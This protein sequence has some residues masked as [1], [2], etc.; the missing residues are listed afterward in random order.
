MKV[1]LEG[2]NLRLGE[3]L[4][5]NLIF[6]I[7]LPRSGSTLL[8]HIIASHSTVAATAE[9]WILFP[10]AYALRPGALSANYNADIGRIALSEFLA[11]LDDGEE[12]YYAAVRKMALDLYNAYLTKQG[13]E[14]FIDKTSRYYLILPELFY[15]FPKANYVFL[16]RNPLATFASFLESMVFQN[17][18]RLG[19]RGIRNDLLDGYRLIREGI[20]Y[21]GD[22]AIVVKYEDLVDNPEATVSQL[23]ER[24]GLE[25]EPDMLH[26]GKKV[27]ILPGKLVDPK[28]IH[29]HQTPVKDYVDVWRSKL[30]TRQERYFAQAFLAH[31]GQELIGSLGYP[32]EELA[33]AVSRKDRG[34]TPLV[35]WDVLMT[36]SD[37]RSLLQRLELEFANVWQKQD[38]AILKYLGRR[39]VKFASKPL[40]VSLS[41]FRNRARNLPIMRPVRQWVH[42][43]RRHRV[44]YRGST[45]SQSVSADYQVI[46]DSSQLSHAL[47]GGWQMP[48]VAERQLAAYQPLLRQMSEGNPRKDFIVAAQ[49]LRLT[50]LS[51]P[52]IFEIGCGNGYYSEVLSCLTHRSIKYVGLDYSC[53][54]IE[55]A[56]KCYPDSDH[57]FIVGDATSLPF[58]DNAFD[59]AWSGTILMHLP[60]YAK[61]ITEARRISRRF[62]IFH[63][64]P[65]L[66][67]G[68]TTFLSKKAYGVPVIEIIISQTEL[69]NLIH[70]HGMV[71][72][73]VLESLP[74]SAN[75]VINGTIHTLTYVC[76]V[77]G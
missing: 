18:K 64:T 57:Q 16:I 14:R 33:S 29:K 15:I 27:G 54:M 40:C 32:Y 39:V 55:S 45:G 35:R 20:R 46:D 62:C 9:P 75:G 53:A 59:I 76:E 31:L 17:W 37:Q 2:S 71:I 58:A 49:A 13:K 60:D 26:Y 41:V 4:G 56:R 72:R 52:T 67:D 77:V 65:V 43:I 10:A 1:D 12:Q 38:M 23:C 28:S 68:S 47:L 21:F 8:Q 69:E 74:Y 30:T 34:W 5:E 7:S 42:S 24:L 51:N 48:S 22:G 3:S 66:A 11:L 61:A 50:N 25:F 19:E 36:P 70:N 73:N 6:L 44:P 63:S